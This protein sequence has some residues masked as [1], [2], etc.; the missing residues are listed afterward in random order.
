LGSGFKSLKEGQTV[1]FFTEETEKGLQAID[2]K[3]LT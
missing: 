3:A 1:E 2:V